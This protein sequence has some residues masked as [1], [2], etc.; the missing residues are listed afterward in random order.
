MTMRKWIDLLENQKPVEEAVIKLRGFSGGESD[1]PANKM[2][3][4]WVASTME[5]PFS[6]K[7]QM[8]MDGMANA[9]LRAVSD[10]VV[11][12]GDIM[13][14][15]RGEG[16]K[17]LKMICSLADQYEVSLEL[18]AH[19]YTQTPTDVLVAWY[20]RHGFDE[21][22]GDDGKVDMRRE[23][24]E[25]QHLD[26]RARATVFHGTQANRAL[27]ILEQNKIIPRTSQLIDGRDYRGISVS[28]SRSYATHHISFTTFPVVLELDLDAIKHTNKV[29]PFD[30]WSHAKD[31]RKRRGESEEFIVGGIALDR[32]LVAIH[33]DK[34]VADRLRYEPRYAELLN[35]PKAV[36]SGGSKKAEYVGT[37][38]DS[39]DDDGNC[40]VDELPWSTVSDFARVEENAATVFEDKFLSVC[41]VPKSIYLST[42]NS[43]IQCLKSE[44]GVYM[45]YDEGSDVHYFFV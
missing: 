5:H 1:S 19:G 28:R 40:I 30:F 3:S 13:S 32:V 4:T 17:L 14:V 12:I 7:K 2:L 41:D 20:T 27:S 9:E 16:T 24:Q 11:R 10:D 34:D 39:F 25:R 45:L 8:A 38:V 29:I 44:D 35:H 42:Q 21:V 26:E 15:Q 22:G 18:T 33:I 6:P 31:P 23:P 36:V 43:A 37:C